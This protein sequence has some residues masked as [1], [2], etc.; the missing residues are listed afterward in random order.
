VSEPLNRCSRWLH[1][2]IGF[3]VR[4]PRSLA[5]TF[6]AAGL[7]A[8]WA[9]SYGLGG[10]SL[11]P[12]HWFY[13]IILL[14]AVRFGW[15]G[16]LTT[17]LVSGVLAGPLL[18][19]MVSTGAGQPLSD[20]L[21]R[22]GFF[23]LLG[24]AMALFVGLSRQ[25]LAEEVTYLR[26]ER[27]FLRGLERGEFRVAYQPIVDL[28]S[29]RI[30]GVE[31]L[32]RWDHPALGVIDPD[33]FIPKAEESDAIIEL[34]RFVLHETCRQITDWKRSVLRDVPD[35]KVAVNIS[36][37]Q[38]QSPA[39]GEHVASELRTAGLDP[40]W[41]HLEVTETALIADLDSA[42][43]HLEAMNVLGVKIAIDDFGTGYSSLA[44]L[45]KLAVDVIKIDQSFVASLGDPGQAGVIAHL[46]ADVASKL[47]MTSVAEGVETRDQMLRLRALGCE[48]GQGFYFGRPVKPEPMYNL[49]ASSNGPQPSRRKRAMPPP[50]TPRPSNGTRK[51]RPQP[52]TA[53]TG[54]PKLRRGKGATTA[55]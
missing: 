26:T 41:L 42:C 28:A 6:T 12:P 55:R 45:H 40:S 9:L 20:W 2:L 19:A 38:F 18:P 46:V 48:L 8:C 34:G 3:T 25:S 31:A 44:Y 21:T 10:A 36:T 16:A 51:P 27:E 23:V 43:L 52:A 53:A 5:W 30:V 17:A 37:R 1:R 15:R 29:E 7:A 49:L 4:A 24:Q 11:F 33:I 54:T 22:A 50:V 14:A 35:F 13:L 47:N 39:F 32:L